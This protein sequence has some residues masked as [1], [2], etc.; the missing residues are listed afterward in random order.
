VE[1]L[2]IPTQAFRHHTKLNSIVSC[3]GEGVHGVRG[4]G[5]VRGVHGVGV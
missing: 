4:V 3:R 1:G 2:R 5:G